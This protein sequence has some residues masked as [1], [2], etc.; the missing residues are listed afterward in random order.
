MVKMKNIKYLVIAA[1]V[2]FTSCSPSDLDAKREELK[3]AKDE[4][5]ALNEKIE[6]IEDEIAK[7]DTT[8]EEETI[9]FRRVRSHKVFQKFLASSRFQ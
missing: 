8:K 2:A 5:K 4:L 9:L 6:G 7:L 1:V 3:K